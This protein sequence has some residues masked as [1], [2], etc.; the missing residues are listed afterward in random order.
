MDIP[1]ILILVGE[2]RGRVVVVVVAEG[3]SVVVRWTMV[4]RLCL[5]CLRQ[6]ARWIMML[7]VVLLQLLLLVMMM[8]MTI[9]GMVVGQ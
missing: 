6:Y 1:V 3:F 9:V 8:N 7:M 4:L 5:R 2:R